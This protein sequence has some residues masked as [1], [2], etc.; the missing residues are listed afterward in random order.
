MCIRDR[1]VRGPLFHQGVR[2]F[3]QS[4]RFFPPRDVLEMSSGRC[5]A[6]CVSPASSDSSLPIVALR[7]RSATHWLRKGAHL[8]RRREIRIKEAQESTGEKQER[9]SQKG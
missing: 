5:G 1:L 4:R 8:L 7:V 6:S 2:R 9:A 3:R